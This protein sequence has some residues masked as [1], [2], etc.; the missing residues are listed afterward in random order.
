MQCTTF[1]LGICNEATKAWQKREKDDE[2]ALLSTLHGFNV[3]SIFSHP[4]TLQNLTDKDRA[5]AAIHDS[6]LLAKE[7]GQEKISDFVRQRL[8]IPEQ[9]DKPD[10]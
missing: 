3:F 6:L 4:E 1:V 2:S 5:P 8:I 7:L 9:H 10:V